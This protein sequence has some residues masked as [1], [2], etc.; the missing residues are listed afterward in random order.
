LQEL[1]GANR[2][3]TSRFPPR[4]RPRCEQE[5]P[6]PTGQKAGWSLTVSPSPASVAPPMKEGGK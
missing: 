4:C 5:G 3:E 2:A 6:R 1:C